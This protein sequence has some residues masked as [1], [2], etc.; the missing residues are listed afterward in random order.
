MPIGHPCAVCGQ[1]LS[2][3]SAALDPIYRLPIVVCPRWV[4]E[5]TRVHHSAL[6][7]QA[8]DHLPVVARLRL[9]KK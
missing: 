9:P 7:A 3:L 4:V 6:A 2:R 1:D 5:E 8:S